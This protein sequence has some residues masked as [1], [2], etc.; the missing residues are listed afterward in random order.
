[1]DT[2]DK[3]NEIQ[4][5]IK[6][7]SKDLNEGIQY[8]TSQIAFTDKCELMIYKEYRGTPMIVKDGKIINNSE[9]ERFEVVWEKEKGFN[10]RIGNTE[11]E[12]FRS[13]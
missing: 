7:L 12:S 3:L 9:M 5:Q 11:K 10:I 4:D 6:E 8:F 2:V 13:N 1:M